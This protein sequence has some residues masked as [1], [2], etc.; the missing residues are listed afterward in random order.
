MNILDKFAPLRA[1]YA[2]VR[3]AGQDPF[4]VRFERIASPTEGILNGRPVLLLGTNNYLGLTFDPACLEA[5]VSATEQAGTGT[6][7]SRIANGTYGS[8]A[9]LEA[10]I[11]NFFGR[12]A[13]MVFTT[14]Y[15]ANLGILSTLAGRDDH[16]V[17]DA[18]SHAS[19]YDGAKLS[20]AR[21]TRFRH[22]DP[23][24]LARRLRL[25]RDVPGHKLIVVEGIYSMLGDTAP[26]REIAAVKREAGAT[27][28]VDEAHS[29]GVLGA[30]GRGLAEAAGVEADVDFVVG[31]FS[32][33]LGAIGGFCVS[34]MDGFESL[35]VACRP[36]MFTASLPPSVTASVTQA[37]A[38]LEA[39]PELRTSLTRNARQLYDGLVAAGFLLGP[40][41]SP[42]V[43]VRLSSP[44]RA[45][46][47]WNALL[48][49]GVYVN[50]ALPPATPRGEALLRLSVSAAH[51]P[52]QIARAVDAVAEVGSM[53]GLTDTLLAAE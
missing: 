36:Y 11:A 39:R 9:A 4:A 26:L 49:R 22:N 45:V 27:L 6:T 2:G 10:R 51:T 29:L 35:R 8:H 25:L 48:A 7:G 44:E 3:A 53:L 16:L 37:L 14:G 40:A 12:R 15:Q 19:I 20:E 18:D 50:L 24:D 42:I 1:A 52:E 41:A 43:A 30:R 34:D 47:A 13:G 5:A 23:E 31:T 17:L 28:L 21:V 32:K 33:S 38:E 46:A